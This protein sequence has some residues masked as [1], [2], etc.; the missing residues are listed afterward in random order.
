MEKWNSRN[1][2]SVLDELMNYSDVIFRICLGFSRNPWDA[3]DLMQDVYL[4]ALK[5]IGSLKNSCHLRGWLLKIAKN[6]CLNHVKKQR[7]QR[8][9]FPRI[10]DDSIDRSTP[11]WRFMRKEQHNIFKNAVRCLPQKLRAVF[12]LK[13]Y[14][15]LSCQEIA[16]T[17]GIKEGTV[18]SRASRA[19]LSILANLKEVNHG[20]K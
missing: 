10:S 16:Q 19:R 8:F 14:G 4:K 11:E 7:L 15:R 6:T 17:L 1:G 3:E 20:K 13:E 9:L 2:S 5:N 12:I 18:M